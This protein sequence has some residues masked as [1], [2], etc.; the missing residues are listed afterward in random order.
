MHSPARLTHTQ[1]HPAV[2]SLVAALLGPILL[3]LL[4]SAVPAIAQDTTG[5]GAVAGIVTGTDEK[6]A[7]HVTVCVAGITRCVLTDTAGRF[8]IADLRAGRY[9]LQV[10]PPG[11]PS[12]SSTEFDIHAGVETSVEF[13]LATLSPLIHAPR[14]LILGRPKLGPSERKTIRQFATLAFMRMA[15][16]KSRSFLAASAMILKIAQ[17]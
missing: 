4:L 8:R 5:V 16:G 13:A 2:N 10:T 15:S 9:R 17:G 3:L 1:V 11:Q 14:P 6:P 12:R 7:P